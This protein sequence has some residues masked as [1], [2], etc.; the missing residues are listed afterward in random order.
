MNDVTCHCGE[1]VVSKVF[2]TCPAHRTDEE[3]RAADA[4]RKRLARKGRNKAGGDDSV[5]SRMGF[6]TDADEAPPATKRKA[7]KKPKAPPPSP[8]AWQPQFRALATALRL[9]PERMIEEFCRGWVESTRSRALASQLA[10][11]PLLEAGISRLEG[12][13]NPAAD[14]RAEG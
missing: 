12:H 7:A 14:Q 6:K 5:L 2:K 8:V 1:K 3:R 11:V 4:E 10:P 13:L 9:D